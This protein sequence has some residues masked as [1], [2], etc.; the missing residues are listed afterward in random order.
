MKEIADQIK[1]SVFKKR[2]FNSIK[3]ILLSS[4]IWLSKDELKFNNQTSWEGF[5]IWNISWKIN[6]IILSFFAFLFW[7][8]FFMNGSISS[9]TFVN[10]EAFKNF[11][12]FLIITNSLDK[13]SILDQ[14]PVF[15]NT[16]VSCC[17]RLCPFDF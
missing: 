10:C 5:W 2:N 13:V 9:T 3:I 7:K 17:F 12:D 1:K 16:Y 14:I 11:L 15:S 8:K 4:K 6:I